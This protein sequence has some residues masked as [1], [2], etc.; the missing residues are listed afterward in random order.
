MLC[1]RSQGTDV[2]GV[3]KNWNCPSHCY[4]QGKKLGQLLS[5]TW[6]PSQCSGWVSLCPPRCRC[7]VWLFS[8]IVM[9]C[10]CVT[11]G[12]YW[13]FGREYSLWFWQKKWCCLDPLLRQIIQ[14]TY[15]YMT[16]V[17][18]TVTSSLHPRVASRIIRLCLPPHPRPT[19]KDPFILHPNSAP[20][21][22]IS[23]E[24]S[25][26]FEKMYLNLVFCVALWWVI[27]QIIFLVAQVLK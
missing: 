8:E 19:P 25:A 6:L 23:F 5:L 12:Y 4:D 27:Y 21:V 26:S 15:K 11:N 14:L 22:C 2:T 13:S 1:V 24:S 9:E 17:G 18:C 7:S 10:E 3:L 16:F 20:F